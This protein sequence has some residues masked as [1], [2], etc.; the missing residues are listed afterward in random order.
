MV[1]GTKFFVIK[2]KFPLSLS[3]ILSS[4]QFVSSQSNRKLVS[5]IVVYIQIQNLPMSLW[6]FC[7]TLETVRI[8]P[9]ITPEFT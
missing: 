4:S 2:R 7:K 8:Q 6:L 9:N 3:S 5:S 1:K